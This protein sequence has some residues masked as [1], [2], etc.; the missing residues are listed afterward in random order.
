[1]RRG[2]RA[3]SSS[4][5]DENQ[6]PW[7]KDAE[8]QGSPSERSSD[9]DSS[10]DSDVEAE[11]VMKRSRRFSSPFSFAEDQ[12]QQSENE[13]EDGD[14]E[15]SPKSSNG[16]PVTDL[17]EAELPSGCVRLEKQDTFCGASQPSRSA[18]FRPQDL[19]LAMTRCLALRWPPCLSI[20]RQTRAKVAYQVDLGQ[21]EDTQTS[22]SS[23]TTNESS[24]SATTSDGRDVTVVKQEEE[25]VKTKVVK[26]APPPRRGVSRSSPRLPRN[27]QGT[28]M[29]LASMVLE[30][31][32]FLRIELIDSGDEGEDLRYRAEWKLSEKTKELAEGVWH[33][34]S[35]KSMD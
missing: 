8:D 10:S 30:R 16:V 20:N 21:L 9:E 2:Q 32:T 5:S 17:L 19:W 1:M 4:E 35:Q 11:R 33:S 15:L 3:S 12:Q 31:E 34:R 23:E 18:L 22:S 7:S 27:R 25:E 29:V 6:Q 14:E 13:D 28:D 26:S 24:S